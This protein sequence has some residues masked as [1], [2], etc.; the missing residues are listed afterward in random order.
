[1]SS[2]APFA[3]LRRLSC[4]MLLAAVVGVNGAADAR[5]AA[6]LD[7]GSS[8]TGAGSEAIKVEPKN[9]ID[10]GESILSVARRTSVFFVNQTTQ[11]IQVEKVS[12]NGDGNVTAEITNDDCSKQGSI[13]PQS[14]CSVEVSVTPSTPGNWSVD[15]LMTHNGA[16]R[17]ARAKLTGKTSGTT[18]KDEKKDNGLSLN[19]KESNPVTFGELEVGA[20][21][22][23]SALMV[24]DSVEPITLYAIDVIEAENGLQRLD[25]GCAVDME[26]K[27]GESCPVTLV[28]TPNNGGQISTDLIIRHSGRL[29]FAV[30]PVRGNAKGSAIAG[31]T[32]A[33]GKDSGRS[34]G[35]VIIESNGKAGLQPPPSAQDLEKAT[36]G[37][38]PAVSADILG[39]A[40]SAPVNSATLRLIGMVGNRAVLLKTDGTTAVVSQGDEFDSGDQKAKLLSLKDRTAT[41]A[42]GGKKKILVMGAA[43]ELTS[44][45]SSTGTV[46]SS[47]NDIS[48][49]GSS[50]T[51]TSSLGSPNGSA[52]NSAAIPSAAPLLPPGAVTGQTAVYK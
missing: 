35:K 17:I 19:T 26:L 46:K 7:P 42:L 6:F 38:I 32:N 23:R 1:M 29:G 40:V 2:K 36:A 9:E 10:T 41:I 49:G 51:F 11:P 24:N 14:R 5:D 13:P 8:N 20:K 25:Q 48:G 45:A 12:V 43:P 50:G 3:I 18:T 34:D 16:G 27:P 44:R 21:A 52:G 15:V 39:N 37:K 4:L 47:G 28:W 22:V 33:T 30:I 31:G